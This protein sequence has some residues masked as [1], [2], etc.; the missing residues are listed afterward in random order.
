MNVEQ[1]NSTQEMYFLSETVTIA[2]EHG[3]TDM[4]VQA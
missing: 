1:R 4:Y 3:E 2:Q